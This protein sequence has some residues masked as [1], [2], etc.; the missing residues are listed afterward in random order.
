MNTAV[1]RLATFGL[2]LAGSFSTAYAVGQRVP[3]GSVGGSGSGHAHGGHAH[4][5]AATPPA[6]SMAGYQL[7]KRADSPTGMRTF[8]VRRT[9]G[10]N[11]TEFAEA[12]GA[13]LHAILIRPDLSDFQHV[14]PTIES[15]GSFSVPNPGPGAWHVVFDFVAGDTNTSVVLA[16]N[17]DD[18]SVVAT[19]PLPAKSDSVGIATQA[20]TTLTVRR[21][22]LSFSYDVPA[23]DLEPFLGQPAHLI[24]IR[25]TDLAY[26][27][28]HPTAQKM[29][30]MSMFDGTLQSGTY[31]L[32]LQFG[33]RGQVITAEFT[34]VIP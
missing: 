2:L 5:G 26:L 21:T 30:G 34:A 14:H 33:Y 10:T 20:G 17:I 3:G 31:R 11:L 15:D 8:V 27:H 1:A 32:F 6:S 18:S 4:N 19:V 29:D 23:A 9:D 7:T 13:K 22:G 12:H 28:L 24:A 16:T 25:Q